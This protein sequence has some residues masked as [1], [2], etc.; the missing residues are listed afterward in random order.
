M[1]K[2]KPEN[3]KTKNRNAESQ[4]LDRKK[5]PRGVNKQ[6]SSQGPK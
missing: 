4:Q 2:N 3:P 5:M 6:G 1:G